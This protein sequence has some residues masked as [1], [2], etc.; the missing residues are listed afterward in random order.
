MIFT[1]EHLEMIEDQFL[2]TRHQIIRRL[3]SIEVIDLID[4]TSSNLKIHSFSSTEEVQLLSV[5]VFSFSDKMTTK[6]TSLKIS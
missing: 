5:N 3:M 1:R 2:L 6:T 4:T